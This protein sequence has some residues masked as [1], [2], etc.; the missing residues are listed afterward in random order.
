VYSEFFTS[1][2][3]FALKLSPERPT[4]TGNDPRRLHGPVGL[5]FPASLKRLLIHPGVVYPPQCGFGAMNMR[6]TQLA[7]DHMLNSDSRI[8]LF[9]HQERRRRDKDIQAESLRE[10]LDR[11]NGMMAYWEETND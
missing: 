7:M 2:V 6:R 5:E 8:F 10:W 1:A 11:V 3:Q 4:G 9:D